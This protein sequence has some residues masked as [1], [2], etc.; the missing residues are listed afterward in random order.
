MREEAV[1]ISQ[2]AEGGDAA[3]KTGLLTD[4]NLAKWPKMSTGQG[5]DI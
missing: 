4:K 2:L 3:K 1:H 5:L